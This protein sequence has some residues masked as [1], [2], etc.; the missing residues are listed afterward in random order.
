[1]DAYKVLLFYRF[2][3]LKDPDA[4]RLWQRDLCE[5][6]GL[7]GRII[8]SEVGINAT[9]GGALP[10][11]KK[12]WRKTKD[13]GPFAGIDFKWSEGHGPDDF[14]KL[15]VK[16]RGELVAYGVAKHLEISEDGVVGAGTRIDPRQL[17]ELVSSKEVSFFD[18]R[19]S[20]EHQ[21]GRFKGAIT[22]GAHSSQALMAE[23]ESGKFDHLKDQT[24]VTYCT[25]GIRCEVFSMMMKDRGFREV[26]Q[27]DGGIMSYAKEFR[28]KGLWEGSLYTFDSR[29]RLSFS[30]DP[31]ILG[32]CVICGAPS[33]G[34]ENC[35]E[36][37]CKRQQVICESCFADSVVCDETCAE[38]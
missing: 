19:N 29:K 38:V 6:L 21:I 20:W 1:M 26:Y 9:I 4:I 2:V 30:D 24:V 15:S 37:S 31:K 5:S 28:D 34:L 25:G 13:Y 23:L 18:V 3:R 33:A 35:S 22:S 10:A 11:V 17:H 12:Y 32:S 27:I 16:L 7:R 8:V 14:P 36:L